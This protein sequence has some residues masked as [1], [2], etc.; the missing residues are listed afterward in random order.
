MASNAIKWQQ[1]DKN[2]PKA[3]QSNLFIQK[4]HENGLM[5]KSRN[6]SRPA[7]SL[8]LKRSASTRDT[9]FK[10]M[11][12]GKTNVGKTNKVIMMVGVSGAG[13]S[14]LINS[15]INHIL[16]VKWT[17][18]VRVNLFEE[19]T[20][21][22][23]AHS[24]TSEIN[25]YKINHIEGFNIPFSLT[26]I[27]TPG[28]GHTGGREEDAKIS[29][30]IKDCFT[31]KW[32]IKHID[33]I[34][35][36]VKASDIRLTPEQRY[37]FDSILSIFGQNIKQNI[38]FCFTFSELRGKPKVLQTLTDASIPCALDADGKPIYFKFNNSDISPA[39]D[40]DDGEGF[41]E[42]KSH[43]EMRRESLEKRFEFLQH[44][45]TK[46]LTLTREVLKERE[47]LEN[48][49]QGLIPK[50]EEAVVKADLLERN[51]IYLEEHK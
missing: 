29:Q 14:T 26:V 28:F 5:K 16:G 32:G 8:H 25:V 37:V 33:A 30:Q 36:V 3:D 12:F 2:Q 27:D 50:I 17:D 20:N 49:L 24:Q 6:T 38:V 42:E 35:F 51:K 23:A 31:S 40:E 1:A 43:W 19:N 39:D 21:K 9:S 18:K 45:D 7:Y 48:A 13:K 46:S 34:A 4:L 10:Q 41:P 22:S 15:M 11:E 47:A 44:A